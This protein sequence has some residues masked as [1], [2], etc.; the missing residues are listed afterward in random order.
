MNKATRFAVEI[1][2]Q[3]AAAAIVMGLIAYIYL[4]I[5]WKAKR[6]QARAL[7]AASLPPKCAHLVNFPL[8]I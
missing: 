8:R 7:I 1:S 4:N 2:A 5:E 6:E 3:P